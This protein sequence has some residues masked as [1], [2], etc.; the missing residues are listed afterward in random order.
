MEAGKI[1]CAGDWIEEPSTF[2][3]GFGHLGCESFLIDNKM[4]NTQTFP[5]VY[6]NFTNGQDLIPLV[7]EVS[8]FLKSI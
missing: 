3:V 4:W 1:N 8:E 2:G 6:K 5:D 7:K